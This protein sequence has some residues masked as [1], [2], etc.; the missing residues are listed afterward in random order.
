MRERE[1]R[2][3]PNSVSLHLSLQTNQVLVMKNQ[4]KHQV[5]WKNLVKK[6][7]KKPG[8]CEKKQVKNQEVR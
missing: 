1:M 8:A 7:G 5:V 4:V 6:P 2:G 3:C